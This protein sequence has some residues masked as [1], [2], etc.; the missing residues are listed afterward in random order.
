M[1]YT[2]TAP[3]NTPP[4]AAP[5]C[6]HCGSACPGRDISSGDKLFCCEGCRLVY[7]VLENKGLC[8]Y[9]ELQ[10]HPG[11]KGIKSIRNNKYAFLDDADI[12]RPLIHFRHAHQCVVTFYIPAVHCSSCMWLLEHL[13]RLREGVSSSRLVFAKKEVTIHFS[14]DQISLRQVAELLATIGYPPE[15][16]LQDM[17]KEAP[18][19][20]DR[21][22]LYRLGIAGFCFANI[23]MIS[24]PEYLGGSSFLQRDASLLRSLNLLLSLPVFFYAAMPFFINAW[25]GLRIRTVNIDAPIALALLITYLRSIY[26]IV[27]GTGPG[28][29]DSMSGI[30]FFM[31]AGRMVQE[32][33]YR[34]LSFHRN[35][36]SYFPVAVTVIR[37]KKRV[38]RSLPDLVPGDIAELRY[39]EIIPADGI[40]LSDTALIDYSFVTGESMPLQIG[41]QEQ[42]YAGGRVQG[43]L[44]LMEI[45]QPVSGSYLTGLWNHQAFRKD[46]QSD[47]ARNSR[48]HTISRYF[49]LVLLALA[50]L[51]AGYWWYHDSSHLWNAVT[52]MLIVAC[53]CALLLAASFTNGNLLR[54][55]SKSGLYLRNAATLEILSRIRCIAFDKTGTLTSGQQVVQA[56]GPVLTE[57]ERSILYSTVFPSRHPYS[58]A[59]A[60]HLSGAA[61]QAPAHWE[62]QPGNGICATI[63]GTEA[64]V[65]NAAWTG[66]KDIGGNVYARIGEKLVSFTVSSRPREHM[67]GV[68]RKLGR[69]RLALLSGDQPLQAN[70]FRKLMGK[71]AMLRFRLSPLE[72]LE[73]IRELQEN[74]T[75]VL[76]IGDGLNDAGALQQSDVGITLAEDINNF[77]PSC[78]AILDARSLV[79]LP[80]FLQMARRGQQI[81]TFSFLVS[82]CYNICGLFFAVQGKL[83]PMI[84]AILMPA[85]TLSIILVSTGLSNLA[86]KLLA[87]RTP[88]RCA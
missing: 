11:L 25:K 33:S 24:F 14:D 54:I 88:G 52:A 65:G 66:A 45:R 81:I 46:K 70:V 27:S 36:Q 23:M 56:S 43:E 73:L 28:Y 38:P 17:R 10:Q 79:Q 82:L 37:D 22:S 35:Y 29:L 15:I 18:K 48:I 80:A 26:E 5:V 39:E 21:S 87:L 7:E 4:D 50:A 32:R 34:F 13:H 12:S 69:Y 76:M 41:K 77:T 51:T 64:R 72:K 8:N 62:E 55:F 58:R 1:R 75:R 6:Y 9:Y 44:L 49:T 3:G 20:S 2:R 40:L 63:T 74:D 42:V 60:L 30:V 67:A 83:Q 86:A 68:I 61:Q 59:L 31:L 57:Q 78:D 47:L 71:T 84:A 19:K 16:S 85:S 53:P